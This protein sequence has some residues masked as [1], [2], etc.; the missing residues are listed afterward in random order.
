MCALRH[1]RLTRSAPSRR[2]PRNLATLFSDTALLGNRHLYSEVLALHESSET[3]P[4]AQHG[5]SGRFSGSLPTLS[6][7]TYAS[8][9]STVSEGGTDSPP[10]SA[11]GMSVPGRKSADNSARTFLRM[12]T[13][14]RSMFASVRKLMR[15]SAGEVEAREGAAG[16]ASG[17][18][19]TTLA[20]PHDTRTLGSSSGR[21]VCVV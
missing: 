5:L 18:F 21:R 12:G 19:L 11:R 15:S 8:R 4:R 9:A 20:S 13:S 6:A 3:S 2:H 16:S 7:I 14:M 1:A 17:A 10:P